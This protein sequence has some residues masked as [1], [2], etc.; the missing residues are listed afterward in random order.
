MKRYFT[1]ICAFLLLT[2][3]GRDKGIDSALLEKADEIAGMP[4]V[5]E[6]GEYMGDYAPETEYSAGDLSSVSGI[7]Y[8]Y[9][10]PYYAALADGK[11]FFNLQTSKTK[12]NEDGSEST[13]TVT[14]TKSMN[15]E[16][17]ESFFLCPDP[18]CTHPRYS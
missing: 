4:N 2:S 11:Y 16:T 14:I 8:A 9:G 18:L 5:N 1:F 17:G 13:G 7:C 15:L 3:C 10:E 6:N 12:K